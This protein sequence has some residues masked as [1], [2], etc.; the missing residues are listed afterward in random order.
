MGTPRLSRTPWLVLRRPHWAL[1]AP[2]GRG[3]QVG[4]HLEPSR[5]RARSAHLREGPGCW[6]P[7]VCG[8]GAR[9]PLLGQFSPRARE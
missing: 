3:A 1:P 7:V 8:E 6:K 4:Q 9:A 5:T 2:A